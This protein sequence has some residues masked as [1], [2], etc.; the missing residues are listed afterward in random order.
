MIAYPNIDPVAL[1]LGPLNIHWYG[2]MYVIGFAAFLILGKYRAK[3]AHSPIKP[4]Q[5]DD[6]MFYG[7][8]GV[9]L[10]GRIGYML[11]YNFQNFLNDPLSLFQ[12][13]QGG[14]SFHGGLLGVIAAVLLLAY[15]WRISFLALA[16][17]IAPLVPIGLGAGRIGNFIN[18]NLW[19][20]VTDVPW[21]MVFPNGGAEP[22]HPSQLYQMALEGI[23]LFIILWLFSRKPRP[24]GAVAGLF[25]MCYAFFRIII[26]FVRVPDAQL[27]YIAF[28]WVTQGQLLSLPML[29]LGIFLF[30]YAYRRQNKSL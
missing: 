14:M 7:A 24:T 20:T 30:T 13:W 21:A 4:E 9:V 10:G 17:F 15:R 22:R 28:G 18:G 11:F 6:I 16:D 5:V 3:Q 12:V 23:A 8:L 25:L 1:S 27:G 29:A 19:G 26:E 2:L